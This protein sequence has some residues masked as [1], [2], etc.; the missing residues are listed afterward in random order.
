M[1]PRLV[2]DSL[3]DRATDVGSGVRML[4]KGN[5]YMVE[6]TCK[7]EAITVVCAPEL[8]IEHMILDQD[9]LT[10]HPSILCPDC[11]L[12]GFVINGEWKAA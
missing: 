8:G 7:R 11:G 12:H 6:H 10:I 1:I 4:H 3:W 5:T 2:H 9:P